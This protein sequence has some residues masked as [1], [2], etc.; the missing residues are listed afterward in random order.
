MIYYYKISLGRTR[1]KI[2]N[3]VDVACDIYEYTEKLGI[4]ERH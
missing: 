3:W 1:H 2:E 4:V